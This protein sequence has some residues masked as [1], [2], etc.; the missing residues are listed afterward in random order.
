MYKKTKQCLVLPY[1]LLLLCMVFRR[2]YSNNV[3]NVYKICKITLIRFFYAY[4]RTYVAVFSIKHCSNTLYAILLLFNT[5]YIHLLIY[6]IQYIMYILRCNVLFCCFQTAVQHNGI[7][8]QHN[9]NNMYIRF[10]KKE[11]I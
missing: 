8:S 11:N 4:L 10:N 7:S 3:F 2:H 1:A 6:C 5:L 9:N